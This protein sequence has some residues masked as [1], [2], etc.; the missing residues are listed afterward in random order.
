MDSKDY[1]EP[2]GM[3]YNCRIA[4]IS[5]SGMDYVE[6]SKCI[7]PSYN[8]HWGKLIAG[9][10]KPGVISDVYGYGTINAYIDKDVDD[11]ERK[12]GYYTHRAK[13]DSSTFK[14]REF[15]QIAQ[16][17]PFTIALT[18]HY[19]SCWHVKGVSG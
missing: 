17:Y 1:V 11:K 6:Q 14:I 4:I 8:Y 9:F 7:F 13:S 12:K 5:S 2:A 16:L 3:H 19:M 15:L 18:Q 10:G